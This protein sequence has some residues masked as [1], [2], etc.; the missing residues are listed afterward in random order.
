MTFAK[1]IGDLIGGYVVH[2][3]GAIGAMIVASEVWG[4]ISAAADPIVKAMN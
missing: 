4:V 3:A 2:I 1:I